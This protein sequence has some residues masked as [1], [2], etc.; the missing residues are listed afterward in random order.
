MGLEIIVVMRVGS[1]GCGQPALAGCDAR[2]GDAKPKPTASEPPQMW[3][4]G[5]TQLQGA[6]KIDCV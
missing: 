4:L 1:G 3:S 6:Q 5:V 2:G